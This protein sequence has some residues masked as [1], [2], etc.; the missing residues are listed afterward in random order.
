M[1]NMSQFSKF[2]KLPNFPHKKHSK[3][4]KKIAACKIIVLYIYSINNS[5]I[6]KKHLVVATVNFF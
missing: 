3:I 6:L 2:C 4:Q 5:T 1:N